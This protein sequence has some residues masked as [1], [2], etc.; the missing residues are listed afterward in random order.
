I[1]TLWM[2]WIFLNRNT[3]IADYCN[4]TLSFV[5]DYWKIIHQAS[6]WAG[7]RNW[8]LILL[9]NNFLNGQNLARILC[10]YESLVGMNQW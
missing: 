4:G 7:L 6:G 5:A 2:R 10:Y 1:Q 8:L 9:A 3:F